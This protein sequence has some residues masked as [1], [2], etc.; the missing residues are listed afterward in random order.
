MK[1]NKMFAGL[2]AFVAGVALSAGSAFAT[3]G[4]VGGDHTRMKLVPHFEAGETRATIIGIQNLSPQES[5]TAAIHEAVMRAQAALTTA[6]G[7]TPPDPTTIANAETAL[8]TTQMARYTEHLFITVNAHDAMGMM[9]AS[10]TL[11]LAENQFGY[12]SLQGSASMM[13]DS[14]QGAVLSMEDGDLA[15]GYGYVTITAEN[16]K[17]T[18]CGETAPNL[19]TL[20]N[21][22]DAAATIAAADGTPPFGVTPATATDTNTANSRVAAWTII[23]DVGDGF[24]GTEVPTSSITMIDHDTDDTT[25]DVIGCYTADATATPVVAARAGTFHMPQCGLIPE[26]HNNTRDTTTAVLTTSSATPRAT[27]TARYDAGDESMVYVWLAEGM[28]TEATIPSERRMLDVVVKCED[29]TVMM[30]EDIDGNMGPIEVPAPG[31][32]TMID[33]TMG[34]VG[35]HVDMCA[36]DRGVL[37]IMMPDNSHAGMVF[38]HITQMMGHYRMNFPGYSMASPTTCDATATATPDADDTGATV[39]E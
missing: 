4:Y 11:C 7:A 27:A 6:Q 17:F 23:Q 16:R 33:P 12:V 15:H 29:G 21:T 10:A 28:D 24:F 31:M 26:R 32:L 5:T 34:D 39:C 36:G 22:S 14:S 20:V 2:I 19:L 3:N 8:E 1:M 35:M 18:S 30:A 37:E 13:M 38:S 9:M 25:P